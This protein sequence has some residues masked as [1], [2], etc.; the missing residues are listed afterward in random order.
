MALSDYAQHT[1]MTAIQQMGGHALLNLMLG[2][3]KA[4]G[5]AYLIDEKAN[6]DVRIQFDFKAANEPKVGR[7]VITY[8][9]SSDMYN[10]ELW[11]RMSNKDLMATTQLSLEELAEKFRVANYEGIFGE[12]L[13]EL[14]CDTTGLS[15]ARP[16]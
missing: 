8:V 12:Q 16:F 7:V 9:R 2:I 4:M 11:K 10:M 15:L 13:K 3:K 1:A 6:S 5:A 14:F